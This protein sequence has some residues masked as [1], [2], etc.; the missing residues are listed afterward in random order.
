MQTLPEQCAIKSAFLLPRAVL[1][2][3]REQH[4]GRIVVTSSITG[5]PTAMPGLAPYAA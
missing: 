5:T 1:P 4:Y 3:M 2:I